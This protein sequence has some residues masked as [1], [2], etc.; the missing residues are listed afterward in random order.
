MPSLET[1]QS[2]MT[3][4]TPPNV[5]SIMMR[6]FMVFD[7]QLNETLLLHISVFEMIDRRSAVFTLSN[8]K[9]LHIQASAFLFY[10]LTSMVSVKEI[11]LFSFV[12]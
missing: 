5:T 9:I 2:S 7:Q 10:N 3:K 11:V 8:R 4:H 12:F 1:F 6:C